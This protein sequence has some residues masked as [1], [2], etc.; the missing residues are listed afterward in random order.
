MAPMQVRYG[1]AITPARRRLIDQYMHRH[2]WVVL[3]PGTGKGPPNVRWGKKAYQQF[4]EW[5]RGFERMM[6]DGKAKDKT[7][8]NA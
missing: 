4:L 6:A 8:A 5:E 2:S 7:G 1:L 3:W